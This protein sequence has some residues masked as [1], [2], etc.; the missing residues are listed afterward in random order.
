MT[1]CLAIELIRRHLTTE[2]VGFTI[3]LWWEVPSTSDVLRQLAAGGAREGTVVLA[4]AQQAG[5]GNPGRRWYAPSRGNLCGSVLFRPPIAPAAVPVFSFI[6]SLALTDAVWGEG[7]PG[8][9]KWP[10]DVLIE[11][12]TTGGCLAAFRD[13]GARA[14]DV[15]LGF[16][17]N[18][19]A[20]R[21]ALEAALGDEAKLA[22]SLA[23][24][25]GRVI[26]RNAFAASFLNHLEK[27]WKAYGAGGPEAVLRAWRHRDVLQ[28]HWLQMCETG[29]TSR[30]RALGVDDR[31]RLLVEDTHGRRREVVSAETRIIE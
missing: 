24:E 10:N 25:A 22:T 16:G 7:V 8:G 2:T 4:E 27:W 17:V 5:R 28:G 15:V 26:D 29:A 1:D 12:R 11:G 31:G 6:A 18:L 21:E 3:D 19:N 9:I 13:E 30:C 23:E 14:R 20:G